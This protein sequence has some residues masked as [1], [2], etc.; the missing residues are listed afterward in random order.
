MGGSTHTHTHTHSLCPHV[1]ARVRVREHMCACAKRVST[2]KAAFITD[3]I[4]LI[5]MRLAMYLLDVRI[6]RMHSFELMLVCS[7][8]AI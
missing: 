8:S 5:V 4:L 3:H 2:W 7:V 6:V 1:R